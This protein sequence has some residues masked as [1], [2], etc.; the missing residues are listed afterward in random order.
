MAE[1]RQG[2]LPSAVQMV[3]TSGQGLPVRWVGRISPACFLILTAGQVSA[4]SRATLTASKPEHR[5]PL[6]VNKIKEPDTFVLF[7]LRPSSDY[8]TLSKLVQSVAKVL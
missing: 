3:Q 8:V 4:C 5:L 7:I 2:V 1:D 6:Q